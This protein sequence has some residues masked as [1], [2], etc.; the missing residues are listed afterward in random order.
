MG[1]LFL[2]IWENLHLASARAPLMLIPG[3]RPPPAPQ[4]CPQRGSRPHSSL[5]ATGHPE[6]VL[7][8]AG[9]EHE[10]LSAWPP[11]NNSPLYTKSQEPTLQKR[12]RDQD[13]H[14]MPDMLNRECEP[15]LYISDEGIYTCG[16]CSAWPSGQ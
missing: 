15:L 13:G 1:Q 10:R 7:C 12:S 9:H 2:C 6:T 4:C 16:H 5:A 11:T 8:P 3:W 14:K